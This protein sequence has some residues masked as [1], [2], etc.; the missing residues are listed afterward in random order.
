[1]ILCGFDVIPYKRLQ[2]DTFQFW[3]VLIWQRLAVHSACRGGLAFQTDDL[4][5]PLIVWAH[6]NKAPEPLFVGRG[7]N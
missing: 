7:L 4:C 1:M 5:W 3:L 2:L 6:K